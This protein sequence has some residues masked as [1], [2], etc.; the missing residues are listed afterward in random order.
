MSPVYNGILYVGLIMQ[1]VEFYYPDAHRVSIQAVRIPF[2]S[3]VVKKNLMLF[4]VKKVLFSDL[5]FP[6]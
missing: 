1:N 6:K 5:L 4:F 3:S 2:F